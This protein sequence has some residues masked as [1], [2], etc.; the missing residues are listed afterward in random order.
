MLTDMLYFAAAYAIYNRETIGPFHQAWRE[1]RQYSWRGWVE[2]RY[3]KVVL[4]SEL[5]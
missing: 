3:S 5:H 1:S 4:T 2:I